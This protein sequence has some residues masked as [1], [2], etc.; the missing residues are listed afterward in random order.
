MTISHKALFEKLRDDTVISRCT[1]YAHWT[2]PQ[3]MADFHEVGTTQRAVV[4]RDYQEV[5]AL[6]VNHLAAKLAKV[7][8]PVEY[9]FFKTELSEN[10]MKDARQQ[11]SE[12][13]I[14][15]SLARTEMEAMQSLYANASYAQ[16]ILMLK[17]LIVTGNALM[18]RDS[19][20]KACTTFGLQSYA[21]RRDGRGKLLDC[22]LREHT[23]VEALPQDVQEL[24]RESD[25]AKYSRPECPVVLYTRIRRV[26]G[27][28]VTYVTNQQVDTIPVGADSSYP[29]HLCPWFAPTWSLIAGEHYGRGLVE[30]F[31]GG[32]AKLSDLSEAHALYSV[33]L[34][35]VVHLVSSGAGTDI[36]DLADAETGEYVRGDPASVNVHEAGDARKLQEVSAEIDRV[37]MRLAKAFMYEAN[38]RDA[39]RVTAYELARN[40]QEAETAL[41]GAYSALSA[42]VQVPLAHVLLTEVRPDALA[43]IIADDVKLTVIAGVPALGRNSEV[44]GL[45]L[46]A[47]EITV[48]A[49]LAQLD[50]RIDMKRVVDVIFAGRSVDT[51]KLYYS[52][53]EQQ[54]LAAAQQQQQLGERQL[55]QAN[56]LS[57]AADTLSAQVM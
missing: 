51:T 43:G 33:E 22:V 56:S 31:A 54:A 13:E 32:F 7:L 48:L 26:S 52:E 18:Y 19:K 3:L 40:A 21:V 24:L 27:T 4:E 49:P 20:N 34:M 37:F 35:R 30:D 9:P 17:H 53:D 12:T 36:D 44:Q 42:G 39:E 16:L 5:G 38:V 23:Y 25:R 10:L 2:L 45:M 28:T 6:L 46:A 15:A 57:D 29:E 1:Q 50:P 11:F 47:Q 14:A 8:F 55:L 41:G